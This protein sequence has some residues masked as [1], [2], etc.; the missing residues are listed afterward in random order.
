MTQGNTF[1]PTIKMNSISVVV[2]GSSYFLI[3]VMPFLG[4]LIPPTI[5]ATH[6]VEEHDGESI[7]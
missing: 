6:N 1:A 2:H 5:T 7:L 3:L 4:H